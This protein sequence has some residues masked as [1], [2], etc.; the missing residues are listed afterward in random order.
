MPE[1]PASIRIDQWLWAARLFKT[2]SQASR[3]CRNSRIQVSGNTVKPSHH[4]RIGDEVFIKQPPIMRRFRIK[5][6]A[7]KRTSAALARELA[8]E[9]TPTADL[10]KLL[11]ARKDP[12]SLTFAAREKGRGRPTKKE[13]RLLEKLMGSSPD[14]DG[15]D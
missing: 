11:Q 1:S 8:E 4:V 14:T 15:S 12:L 9:T 13:R 10:E 3:A 5:K 6:L 2:R 7:V